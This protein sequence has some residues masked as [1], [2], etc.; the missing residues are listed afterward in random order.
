MYEVVNSGFPENMKE[1]FRFCE[2]NR[3]NL[4]HQNIFRG[5]IANTIFN[6]TETVSFSGPKIWELIPTELR[7]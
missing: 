7:N 1:V 4:G 3:N 6:G 2:E 5:P